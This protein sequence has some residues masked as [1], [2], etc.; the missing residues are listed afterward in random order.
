M[1]ETMGMRTLSLMVPV[2]FLSICCCSDKGQRLPLGDDPSWVSAAAARKLCEDFLSMQGYT[3]AQIE[4]EAA[5]REKCWYAFATNGA[6]VPLKVMVDRKSNK[7]GYG[8]WKH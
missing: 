7:V 3:N 1:A 8:D 2:A 5:V 6:T 4:G